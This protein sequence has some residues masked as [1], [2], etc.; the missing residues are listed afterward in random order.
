MT[1]YEPGGGEG[2][3]TPESGKEIVFGQSLIFFGLK[4]AVKMKK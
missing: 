2:A 4:T 1:V 3:A